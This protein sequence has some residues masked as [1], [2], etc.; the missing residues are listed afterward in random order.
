MFLPFSTAAY[1]A[2]VEGSSEQ[3]IKIMGTYD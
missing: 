3:V 2:E 1:A